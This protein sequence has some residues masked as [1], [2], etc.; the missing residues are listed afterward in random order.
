MRLTEPHGFSE[1]IRC[2]AESAL[3]QRVADDDDASAAGGVFIRRKHASQHRS[4]AERIEVVRRDFFAEDAFKAW[5]TVP[6]PRRGQSIVKRSMAC[7]SAKRSSAEA[8][9]D[10][11]RAG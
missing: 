5:R 7:E 4:H 10:G 8:R 1:H 9:Q 11:R 2:S 6:A 3:P